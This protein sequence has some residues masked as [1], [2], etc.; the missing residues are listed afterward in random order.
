[1]STSRAPRNTLTRDRVVAGAVDL[2]DQEGLDALTIRALAARLG[3]RPMALYHHVAH[4]EAIL[5]AI[6]DAVFAEVHVPTATGRWRD[7]LAH[8]SRSM[9]AALGRHPWAVALM[10]TRA[11]PGRAS[12]ANHEAVLAV[13]S[14]AGFALPAAGHAYAV[15]DAYVYGFALQEA[16]LAS[17]DLEGSAE[18]LVSG[19]D[20]ADF[21]RLAEFAAGHATV[22]GY[23]F[24]DSFEVGLRIVL[25]GLEELRTDPGQGTGPA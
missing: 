7:E 13:L 18:D 2:A 12:L 14:A 5:D 24:G 11:H 3:V 23:A 1:M 17:V 25:D 21:P 8:R 6:V 16:M 19:M 10:E 15:L 22:P 4:K 20:L 9:R